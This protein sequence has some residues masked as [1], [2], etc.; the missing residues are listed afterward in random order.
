MLKQSRR[1]PLWDNVPRS[2]PRSRDMTSTRVRSAA[3]RR[4]LEAIRRTAAS[5]GAVR[6]SP[7]SQPWRDSSTGTKDFKPT[8]NATATSSI[9]LVA[10]RVRGALC[11]GADFRLFF[12]EGN[13]RDRIGLIDLRHL[14]LRLHA[15]RLRLAQ[16]AHHMPGALRYRLISKRNQYVNNIR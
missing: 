6:R 13:P 3:A 15:L 7:R 16:N 8:E 14:S 9:R 12:R 1:A 5:P 4:H 10:Q 11:D 2:L